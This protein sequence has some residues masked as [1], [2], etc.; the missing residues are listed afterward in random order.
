MIMTLDRIVSDPEI[1]D[2]KPCI[3]GTRLTVQRV[4]TLLGEYESRAELREDYPQL[5]DESVRQ[6]LEYASAN[7]EDRILPLGYDG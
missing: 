2:G 7:L 5:D 6:A 4:L 1:L 3:R